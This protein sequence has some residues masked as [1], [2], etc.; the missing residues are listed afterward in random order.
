MIDGARTGGG[1]GGL[2]SSAARPSTIMDR[3]Q[4]RLNANKV[5]LARARMGIIML[6]YGRTPSY[7]LTLL[8]AV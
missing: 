2:A 7:L 1:G 5:S 8:Y 6:M 3:R 4:R